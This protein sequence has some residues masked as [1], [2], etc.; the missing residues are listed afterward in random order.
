[1]R[2]AVRNIRRG[3]A[4]HVFKDACGQR[5]ENVV[6][7]TPASHVT[8]Q[9]PILWLSRCHSCEVGTLNLKRGSSGECD[10]AQ[11]F[12]V[13]QR[14]EDAGGQSCQGIVPQVPA[15]E[16][17]PRCQHHQNQTTKL[18]RQVEQV[19]NVQV[20]NFVSESKMP[21]GSDVKPFTPKS[22]SQNHSHSAHYH[23]HQTK[24]SHRQVRN[25]HPRQARRRTCGQ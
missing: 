12:H 22:L 10:N 8:C 20:L 23:Q 1:M 24:Q 18:Q 7:D 3:Q 21:A 17:Q 6:F 14:V 25:V 19:H 9:I 4:R 5:C 13:C 15:T 11:Q 16:P 2:R